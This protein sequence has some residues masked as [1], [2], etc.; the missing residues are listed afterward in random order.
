MLPCLT[1]AEARRPLV[2]GL[3]LL[4]FARCRCAWL[5][6]KE[7]LDE[8]RS[9]TL[10]LCMAMLS[11][12]FS[13]RE[14]ARLPNP[15][16]GLAHGGAWPPQATALLLGYSHCRARRW[17]ALSSIPLLELGL[18]LVFGCRYSD[19]ELGHALVSVTSLIANPC[20]FICQAWPGVS[21]RHE[22]S[23]AQISAMA[24]VRRRKR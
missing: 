24:G 7:E 16:L 2:L 14:G 22:I 8:E 4:R 18:R 23:A 11:S 19:E 15:E 17:W 12:T 9:S 21:L 20:T 13:V 3:E 6:E 1:M 10:V 5:D